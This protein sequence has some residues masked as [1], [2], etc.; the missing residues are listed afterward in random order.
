MEEIERTVPLMIDRP[1]YDKN[2][3]QYELGE[4]VADL[5]DD[6]EIDVARKLREKKRSCDVQEENHQV[7]Q[8]QQQQMR[9]DG[10]DE[11]EKTVQL[12]LS[13]NYFNISNVNNRKEKMSERSQEDFASLPYL[14]A[15]TM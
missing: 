4:E 8:Q 7:Q 10:A 9:Q 2:S 15:D 13:D 3:G 6:E 14:R 11:D 5:E 12:V 1:E